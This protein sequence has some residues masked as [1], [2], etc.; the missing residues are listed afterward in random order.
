MKAIASPLPIIVTKRWVEKVA[1]VL[2]MSLVLLQRGLK[3]DVGIDVGFRD[4][5]LR[6]NLTRT[7]ITEMLDLVGNILMETGSSDFLVRLRRNLVFDALDI[8]QLNG[9]AYELI[10]ERAFEETGWRDCMEPV[11]KNG[12]PQIFWVSRDVAYDTGNGYEIVPMR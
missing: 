2:A 3:P 11:T 4:S 1:P 12:S 7:G 6:L 9:E 5:G 10:V 8:N